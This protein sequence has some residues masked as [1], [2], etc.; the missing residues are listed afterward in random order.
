MSNE[1]RRLAGRYVLEERIGK[2]LGQVRDHARVLVGRERRE[3]EVEDLR[4]LDEERRG[5]RAPVVLDEV[6]VARGDAEPVGQ[7]DLAHVLRTPVAADLR[8]EHRPL[9][10]LA[11]PP[12]RRALAGLR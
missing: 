2:G 4:E 6:Q 9:V 8:A 7:I 11:R 12:R 1:Q 10:G 5:E 3:I